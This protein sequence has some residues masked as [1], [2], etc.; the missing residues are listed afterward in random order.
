MAAG[1]HVEAPEVR[2]SQELLE[3]YEHVAPPSLST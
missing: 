2:V 1:A 3:M